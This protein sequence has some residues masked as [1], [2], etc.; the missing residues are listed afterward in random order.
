MKKFLPVA[1]LLALGCNDTHTSK[2]FT[3]NVDRDGKGNIEQLYVKYEGAQG[4]IYC[5][6][7]VEGMDDAIHN[8]EQL[9]VELK[10]VRKEMVLKRKGDY[11]SAL[12]AD[13]AACP[14]TEKEYKLIK[15]DGKE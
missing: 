13:P 6:N 1:L 3:V 11:E 2:P 5:V 15:P 9:I 7:S 14:C 12:K 10:R 4:Y 8:A